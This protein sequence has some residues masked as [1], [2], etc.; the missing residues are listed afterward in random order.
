MATYALFSR[1]FLIYWWGVYLMRRLCASA[2]WFGSAIAVLPI[3]A[4]VC[5]RQ[6]GALMN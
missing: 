2:G 1:G 5:H 4:M 6:G 3:A